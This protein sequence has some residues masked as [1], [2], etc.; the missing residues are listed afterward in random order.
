MRTQTR[1]EQTEQYKE[2]ELGLL[3]ESWEFKSISEMTEKTKQMDMRK[4]DNEFKYIDVSGIDR[5]S[6]RII[7]YNKFKGHEAPSRARKIV[8][9]ND[10][11]IATVRPTLKRIAVI[12]EEFDNQVCSTAFCVLRVK[13]DVMDFRYL[14][15]VIQRG[16]F[17]D[18][19]GKI[20]RGASYPAVTDSDIKNQKIFVPPFF[21]QRKIAHVL[22]T[23]QTAQEKTE[24]VITALKELKK[25]M[26]KHLI[27][28][29]PVSLKDAEKVKLKDTKIGLIPEEWD[30]VKLEDAT[31]SMI[32]GGT[33]STSKPE[34]WNGEIPWT[35]SA[36]ITDLY[37]KEGQ[38][39]ITRMGLENSSTHL[40]PKGNLII[41]TRVGV[42]KVAI[43]LVDVAISQDLTGAI[44]DRDKFYVEFLAYY[45]LSNEP[46]K[47]FTL[48]TRGTTIKGIPRD[49]LAKI[50][51]CKPPISKQ[52]Q[53]ASMLSIID[54]KT[55]TDEI[56]K[57]SLDELFKSMLH[58][59]MTAKVRVN[60]LVM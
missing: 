24:H 60:D 32:G 30:V 17:I 19:L 21:E 2:T 43:N 51:I 20:Q 42:G 31:I 26:M 5:S 50:L 1:T 39:N 48:Q 16:K 56:K 7:D 3:P 53:I 37:L 46:Q 15:Y 55:Q 34:Y 27:M 58:N 52:Q 29:G 38:K 11:I 44:I 49:D 4:T 6:L 41:G 23:I 8:K 35:T 13:Q 54:K 25:A 18:N 12:S 57:N 14:Y 10:V 36:Y 33:P 59:L 22:S 47:I 45:L 28:Y 9:K 40:I